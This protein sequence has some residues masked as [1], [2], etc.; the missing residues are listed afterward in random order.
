MKEVNPGCC[1]MCWK[2]ENTFGCFCEDI[3]LL[4]NSPWYTEKEVLRNWMS[5]Y[6]FLNNFSLYK[7]MHFFPVPIKS[8]CFPAVPSSQEDCHWFS[9]DFLSR[10][11]CVHFWQMPLFSQLLAFNGFPAMKF[12]L[13]EKKKRTPK[14]PRKTQT[15]NFLHC[16]ISG[17]QIRDANT[18]TAKF[19]NEFSD[20]TKKNL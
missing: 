2:Q 16:N 20:K 10:K 3:L 14:N 4:R 17:K 5:D 15:R 12:S 19:Y 6:F 11:F 13:H 7:C 18:V 8:E 1:H 9:S